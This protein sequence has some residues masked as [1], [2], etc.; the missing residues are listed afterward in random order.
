MKQLEFTNDEMKNYGEQLRYCIDR[1]ITPI[2]KVIDNNYGEHWGSGSYIECN[3][4]KYLITNEHVARGLNSNSLTHKFHN[5]E[6]I[7]RIKNEMHARAYPIDVCLVEIDNEVWEKV[8][9]DSKCIPMDKLSPKF[10]AVENEYLYVC[11]FSGSRS[12]FLYGCLFTPSTPY[13][14]FQTEL[15]QNDAETFN[16]EFHF[17]LKYL[18]DELKYTGDK[19]ELPDPHGM[20]GSL[21]WNTKIVE[22]KENNIQWTCDM[23][24]VVGILWAW[25]S[26]TSSIISTRIEKFN[27]EGLIDNI[28]KSKK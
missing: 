2:S 25:P 3:G 5:N 28:N 27:I 6:T 13:M 4:V 15:P 7:F 21:V 14:T 11:G 9:H 18:P 1:Y 16:S 23:P 17:A 12:R 8:E 19:M 10:Y 24:V 20:S 26:S 22:C